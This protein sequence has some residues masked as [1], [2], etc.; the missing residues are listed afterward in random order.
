MKN[1]RLVILP[2]TA[3]L[4]ICAAGTTCA[5]QGVPG[6]RKFDEFGD[7][8]LSDIAARLDAFSSELQSQPGM[9]AFVIAYRSRRDL[10][11][12]SGRLMVWTRDYLIHTRGFGP[13]RIMGV[14]GGVAGCVVQELW[15]VPVGA[16][17]KPRSDAYQNEFVDLD[18][19]RKYDEAPFYGGKFFPESYFTTVHASLEGYADA[20]RKEPR[21]S[22]CIIAYAQY[23]V[24][25]SEDRRG[26]KRTREQVQLDPPGT[27]RRELAR[28]KVTLAK[29]YRIPASRIRLV[30]GGYRKWSEMEL[31]IVPRGEHAPIPTPNAFPKGRR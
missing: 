22:A 1:S 15:L 19:A 29:T 21:S 30:D 27:A 7:V 5:R 18:S 28:V 20:L 23:W 13:E 6:A 24:D 3:L 11:G 26:R 17:P 25:R 16:T 12:L 4:I 14:D 8:P 2:L 9:K 10:P 31:W